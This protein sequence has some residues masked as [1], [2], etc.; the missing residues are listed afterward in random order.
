MVMGTMMKRKGDAGNGGDGGDGGEGDE[1][2]RGA[3]DADD[4]CFVAYHVAVNPGSFF[5]NQLRLGASYL[6]P[7]Y[8]GFHTVYWECLPGKSASSAVN[9]RTSG[10][11]CE[12]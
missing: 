4:R 7:L 1:N 3:G 6:S 5:F 8:L 11:L 9:L 10:G 12:V 2:A